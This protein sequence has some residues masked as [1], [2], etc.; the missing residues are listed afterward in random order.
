[1]KSLNPVL[2]TALLAGCAVE[3]ELRYT[4]TLGVQTQGVSLSEDGLDAF[5]AMDGT[6][7]TINTAWGCPTEDTDLPTERE[8]IVDHY[9]GETLARSDVGVH[10]ITGSEWDAADDLVLEGVRTARLTDFGRVVLHQAS[11]GCALVEE[12]A[13]VDLPSQLCA[14]EVH[15]DV[16]RRTGA[17]YA[18][19]ADQGIWRLSI[20]EGAVRIADQGELIA[21]DS[22]L[23][24]TYLASRQRDLRSIDDLGQV[25]WSAED[26][27]LRS[28]SAIHTR[29]DKSDVVVFGERDD[30]GVVLRIDGRTGQVRSQSEVP[31]GNGEIVVSGNGQTLAIVLDDAVHYYA[32]EVD[33]EDPVID[34]DP[35]GCMQGFASGGFGFG[36]D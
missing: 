7:C 22:Q 10:R 29:G 27:P 33:G 13:H 19:T 6:T 30:R 5:A 11:T 32:I 1:M 18:A 23:Q 28:I 25:L 4:A 9:R 34:P 17:M 15:T 26:L 12:Q 16:D 14:S 35:P 31:T 24:S 8:R 2:L 3:N 21:R 36:L 20:A